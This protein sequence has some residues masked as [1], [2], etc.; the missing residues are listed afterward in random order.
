MRELEAQNKSLRE[1][2]KSTDIVQNSD[3]LDK[4]NT[5]ISANSFLIKANSDAA[6]QQGVEYRKL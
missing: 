5:I 3:E 1:I 4:Y 6:T 2:T